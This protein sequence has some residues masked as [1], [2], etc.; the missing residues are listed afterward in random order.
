MSPPHQWHTALPVIATRSTFHSQRQ[1][2][3]ISTTHIVSRYRL[4]PG[5]HQ[6]TRHATIEDTRGASV[7]AFRIIL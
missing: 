1:T 4:L 5:N 3:A 2:V 6:D 7:A